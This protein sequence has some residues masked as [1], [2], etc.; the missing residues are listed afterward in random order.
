MPLVKL[1]APSTTTR[2]GL[3]LERRAF[4]LVLGSLLPI[5]ALT[6]PAWSA[7]ALAGAAVALFA[8]GDA[9]RLWV[10]AFNLWVLRRLGGLFKA[11]EHG[12]LT[13]A[14]YLAVAALIAFVVFPMP[15][16]AQALLFISVGDPAASV[17]GSRFGRLRMG[18]KSV[19]GTAAFL[20][21]ACG[22][23]LIGWAGGLYN[24]LW[25]GL[26]AA[27]VAAAVEA[28]PS[29]PD[30]NLTVPLVS[31]LVLFLTVSG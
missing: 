6:A 25:A 10:P 17:V 2:V 23:A 3:Q 22:M 1:S 30:D 5:I 20:A 11:D 24:P 8:A 29:P 19:E 21:A 27:G 14:T 28:L 31:G 12:R 26:L 15:L 7:Y 16:A 9:A 13:G 18:K 4:H